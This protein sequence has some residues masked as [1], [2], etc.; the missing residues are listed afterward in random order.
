MKHLIYICLAVA[1][2]MFASCQPDHYRTVYP[3]GNPQLS[4][5]LLTSSVRFGADSVRFS[6]Q[7]D[8]SKTP[9]SQLQV[10]VMV[11]LRVVA[12]DL[13]RTPNMHY[14]AELSYYVPFGANMPEGEEV[15]VYLTA[16]N[17]EGTATNL[18]LEGCTGTRPALETLYVMP[19]TTTYTK[20]GKG[21]QMTYDEEKKAFVLYDMH[22]PKNIECLLA[23]TGTRFGR[24]KWEDPV[25]GLMK[26][27]ITLI[28]QEQF[29]D[30]LATSI[31]L[32]NDAYETLD[33]IIFDPI[34][35]EITIGGKVAEPVTT[36]D[37]IN[38]LEE[39]PSF[40]SSS[41]VAKRYR[42]AK[43]FFDPAI[44][45]IELVGVKNPEMA[46]NLD[47]MEYLGDGKVR[48]LGDKGM[49]Y[50]SYSEQYDY[51]I[52]EPLYDLVYPEV[53]YVCGV[54]LG[55]PCAEPVAT[56]GW[57]FDSPEQNLVARAISTNVYQFTAYMLNGENADY[58]DY[59]SLNFK[60]FH[61]HGWGGEEAGG[62]YEQIGLPIVGVGP[63]GLTKKDGST[64]NE[65][66]NWIARTEPIEGIY[67][68]TLDLNNHTTNYEKLR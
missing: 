47:F 7:I 37:V 41:A 12:T 34:T 29:E 26:D 27:E 20:I 38:D 6:V 58:D 60:F 19:P 42:G 52:V 53:M 50:V 10:K 13:L 5:E 36:L 43:I 30:G 45:A 39:N 59:G 33:T 64:G 1:G 35:F 21:K 65:K 66:G 57:G 28:S 32:G 15:K 56:S 14:E 46:Y 25:F 8:E 61:Q 18:I 62:N 23:V 11:G 44:E 9:L 54:G 16:T 55:Q 63:D 31:P 2:L 68:I 49:Y 67:R 3:A 24:I 40:I 48:F 51:I 4:A 17:V 22:W